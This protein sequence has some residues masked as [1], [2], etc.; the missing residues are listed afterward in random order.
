[1][2]TSLTYKEIIRTMPPGLEKRIMEILDNHQGQADRISRPM[3]IRALFGILPKNYK[4]S[5]EDRQMRRAIK[6]RHD[7]GYPVLSDSGE[8]G[9]WLPATVHE[10]DA[11]VAELE[12]RRDQLDKTI[13]IIKNWNYGKSL[14]QGILG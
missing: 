11:Y 7:M 13:R 5:T 14:H 3:L 9:Y 10:A 2:T 12:S 6:T 8:G 1:M 4:D